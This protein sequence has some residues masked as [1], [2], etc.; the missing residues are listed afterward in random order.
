[1]N[2]DPDPLKQFASWY[3][4]AEAAGAPQPEAMALATATRAGRPSVRMVLLKGW[5]ERGFAFYTNL[6]SRKGDELAANARAAL[7]IYWR[8]VGRQ[9]RAAG[10]VS[11]LSRRDALAYWE[12]RPLESQVAAW[13]SPQSRVIESREWLETMYSETRERLAGAPIPLPPFW[14]GFRVR[15]DWI[16]FWEHKPN[17]LHDRLRYTR[18]R[19]GWTTEVL[20]P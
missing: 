6:G 8:E 20:G 11:R 3:R 12:T 16:E 17:R 4:E 9:V 2:A 1:M 13:V 18:R 7:A 10:R 5:G 19:G 14:G 15:P